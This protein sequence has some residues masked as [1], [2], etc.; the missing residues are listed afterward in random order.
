MIGGQLLER[1]CALYTG[2]VNGQL[3]RADTE[4]RLFDDTVQFSGVGHI[5]L[6]GGDDLPVVLPGLLQLA[7]HRLVQGQVKDGDVRPSPGVLP[8]QAQAETAHA[9]GDEAGDWVGG[10]THSD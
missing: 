6:A 3:R 10:A 4:H 7:Q 5:D 8:G 9:S 1:L 2:A